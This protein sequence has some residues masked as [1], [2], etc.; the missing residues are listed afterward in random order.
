MLHLTLRQLKVFESVARHLSYSRAAD[1]LHLT[2]PAVSMQIKQLEDNIGLPLLEQLGKR[3]YLTE[4]GRELYQ[5]SRSI[6]Q[7]LSD[8]EVALDELKGMERGKLNISVVT[9][10]NYFAPHL[11]AK[12]CQRYR[13]VTVSLNVSNREAVLKQLA[14]N[15][16]D[17]AIMGQPPENL[18]IDSESFMENPLVVVAPSDHPL[19]KERFIPVKRLAK[20]IFLV[21]ESG[22]G[23]RSAMERFFAAHKV[24]INKGME[25][26]TTEAIKQAVQAGMGLG[27]MSLHTVELELETNRLKILNVQGFPIVRYW[28]VVNRK[29][30]RLSSVANAFREFLLKEA[31]KLMLVSKRS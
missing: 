2:Q 19:C 5:Y 17:L 12:F 22:S 30:K 25:T 14:D 23:T 7:Q 10:A 28:Y 15:L 4:A 11:L 18:D 1:E 21:R 27:I 3:I 31:E 24:A 6:A 8:M 26:D 29:N 9:T 16:I 20:E 13:G